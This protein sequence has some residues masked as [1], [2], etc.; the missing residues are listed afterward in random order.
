MQQAGWWTNRVRT[1]GQ[2]GF[3]AMGVLMSLA[4][5]AT[6]AGVLVTHGGGP[7][8][9]AEQTACEYDKRIV[10]TA[11]DADRLT[12]PALDYATPA[13]PDGLDEVRASGWLRTETEYWRYTGPDAAGVPQL[14][15]RYPVPGCD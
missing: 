3:S 15:L 7:V 4:A 13:G 12:D 10:I 11:I 14:E 9:A 8:A 6:V 1:R 2:G 5:S